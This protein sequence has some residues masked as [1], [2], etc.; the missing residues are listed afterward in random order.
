MEYCK[1]PYEKEEYEILVKKEAETDERYGFYPDRRP[2]EY[3]ISH[4]II[5]LDKPSG[6]TSHQ[7]VAWLKEILGMKVGHGGTLDPKVTGVLPIGVGKA[8]KALRLFLLAGKEYV[9]WMRLHGDLEEEK[10]LKVLKEFEGEIVQ[11]PPLKSAVKKVPRRK[12]VYC[13]KVLEV[14][15]RDWLLQIATE[16]GVYIRK[17]IY[18]IGVRLGTGA[19]MQQLRRIRV[20]ELKEDSEKYPIVYLQEVVDSIW[21]WKNEGKEEYIRKVFLPYEIS[22]EHLKKVWVLDTAVGAIT[23]GADVYV[24]GISKLYS[25]ILPGDIVGVYTLKNELVAVGVARMSSKE[26]MESNKG[27]A[28]DVDR[29][30]MEKD[31]YPRTWK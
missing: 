10:V 7:V 3:H 13:I 28:I 24:P 9:A 18:D 8:T 14:D 6:P 20:G 31:I 16:A 19:H 5:N 30:L 12:T 1:F 4:S 21:F 15:G 29:V 11:K 25:N 27:I 2:I 17:L 22:A 26:I 23:H